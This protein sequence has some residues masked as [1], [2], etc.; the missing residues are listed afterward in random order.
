M[1][2]FGRTET[3]SL[4]EELFEVRLR[5]VS[6]ERS[7]WKH[8]VCGETAARAGS[9][10]GVCSGD[11]GGPVLYRGAQVGVTSMGPLECAA[12]LADPPDGAS[13]VFTSLYQYADLVNA[14]IHD[15]EKELHMRRVYGSA[16]RPRGAPLTLAA[17]A[18]A[19]LL[20][21]PAR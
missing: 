5:L 20:A 18:G 2:G 19:T 8:C 13:S 1:L 21:C 4:G 14:T 17:C 15:T 10:R 11:S 6:C 9:A 16:A 3:S 12:G 7:S